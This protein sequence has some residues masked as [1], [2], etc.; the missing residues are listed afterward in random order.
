MLDRAMTDTKKKTKYLTKHVKFGEKQFTL[1]SLD[2]ITWSSRREE[3]HMILERQEQER[4]AFNQIVGEQTAEREKTPESEAPEEDGN[5]EK[6]MAEEDEQ[7]L[8][9]ETETPRTKIKPRVGS[10]KKAS[11]AVAMPKAKAGPAPKGRGKKSPIRNAPSAVVASPKSRASSKPAKKTSKS[12][13]KR[14]A[15]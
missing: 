13:S 7:I 8:P 15:A 5:V 1:F 9:L 4:K 11:A 6:L 14:R 12:K 2:G 10:A 3:L